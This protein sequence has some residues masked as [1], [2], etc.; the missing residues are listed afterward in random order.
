MLKH[1]HWLPIRARI[2][3]KIATLTYRCLHG[4]APSYLNDLITTYTPARSL[5]SANALQLVIPRVRL[6]SY[7][8]R[9]FAYAAPSVWNALP[10]SLREAESLSS[11]RSNLKT[12]LYRKHLL[13]DEMSA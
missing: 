12:F 1:L 7:G 10:L 9:A 2:E 11:F 6:E 5:R 8:R 13:A 4:L 3:Y